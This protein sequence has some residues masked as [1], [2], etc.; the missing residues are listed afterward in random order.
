[1]SADHV[2]PKCGGSF[3]KVGSHARACNPKDAEIVRRYLAGEDTA[4]LAREYRVSSLHVCHAVKRFG[5]TVRPYKGKAH[6]AKYRPEQYHARPGTFPAVDARCLKRGPEHED[7]E[8][9][10]VSPMPV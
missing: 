6:G 8:T 3:V 9:V 2:C 4:K 7:C 10:S 5:G 1:M